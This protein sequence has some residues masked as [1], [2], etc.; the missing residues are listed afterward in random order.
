MPGGPKRTACGRDR[1]GRAVVMVDRVMA[2]AVQSRQ[3]VFV[4]PVAMAVIGD[5]LGV[6]VA[7][8]GNAWDMRQAGQHGPA[9]QRQAQNCCYDPHC[10]CL[11]STRHE[12]LPETLRHICGAV[13][14]Y[15]PQGDSLNL[16]QNRICMQPIPP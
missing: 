16:C 4:Q 14:F 7:C 11:F 8:F 10:D 3:K 15:P 6:F 13:L 1:Q 5:H 12:N 2:M 9:D